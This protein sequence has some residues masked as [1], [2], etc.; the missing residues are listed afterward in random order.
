MKQLEK[1]KSVIEYYVICNS[2]KDVIRTGWKIWGVKRDRIES[3]AEHIYGTQMLAIA[4]YSQFSYKINLK[5]TLFMIAIHELEEIVI[6]DLTLWDISKEDK[7]IEGHKAVLSILNKFLAKDELIKLI[8]ELEE[9]KT[10]VAKFVHQCDKLEC[11]LQCKLYDE[12]NTVD[13]NNQKDNIIAKNAEV[14]ELLNKE[15]SW[16]K[17]W[18]QFGQNNYSYDKNFLAISNYAKNNE[19]S[20]KISED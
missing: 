6:G 13:L 11:D 12:Q 15:Q 14:R 5:K 8:D 2:L 19:I 9:R 18:L 7:K 20:Q 1:V 17:A 16:S 4:M 10:K 3:I